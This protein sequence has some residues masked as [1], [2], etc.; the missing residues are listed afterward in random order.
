MKVLMEQFT[1]E[2][3]TLKAADETMR[4]QL[5]TLEAEKREAVADVKKKYKRW[6]DEKEKHMQSEYKRIRDGYE[7]ALKTVKSRVLVYLGNQEKLSEQE[8][9]QFENVRIPR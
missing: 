4:Q 3:D 5:N 1:K 7:A 6:G 9:S 2:R 8:F